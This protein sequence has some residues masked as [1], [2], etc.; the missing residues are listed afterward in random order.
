M[1]PQDR[2]PCHTSVHIHVK[3]T[4]CRGN[5]TLAAIYRPASSPLLS[6]MTEWWIGSRS[7]SIIRWKD[8]FG[9]LWQPVSM[10]PTPA[11]AGW[12]LDK[13]KNKSARPLKARHVVH[14]SHTH[15][16]TEG[17]EESSAVAIG[18]PWGQT[19]R[20]PASIMRP[21]E[22]GNCSTRYC[23]TDER[24]LFEMMRVIQEETTQHWSLPA[25]RG[26]ES[27]CD[28]AVNAKTKTVKVSRD[29]KVQISSPAGKYVQTSGVEK[30]IQGEE[31]QMKDKCKQ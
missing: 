2:P 10:P 23:G 19:P 28:E 21:G 7:R 17:G 25:H 18:R 24:R 8:A 3:Q 11:D 14:L 5:F 6:A 27:A 22:M 31:Q 16:H 26:H 30:L 15:T 1:S 20:W 12:P 9:V 29:P 4:S 13:Q